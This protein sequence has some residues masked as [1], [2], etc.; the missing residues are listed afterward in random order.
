MME[1]CR[2]ELINLV[3]EQ[4]KPERLCHHGEIKIKAP[5][6]RKSYATAWDDRIIISSSASMLCHHRYLGRKNRNP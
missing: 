4:K 5:A 2:P 1:G 3:A 6:E